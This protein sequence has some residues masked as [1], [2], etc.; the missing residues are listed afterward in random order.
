[1]GGSYQNL[2]IALIIF[3][4]LILVSFWNYTHYRI[5]LVLSICSLII[6][7][8]IMIIGPGNYIRIDF[9][10]TSIILDIKT[11]CRNFLSVFFEYNK[12]SLYMII[13]GI[14][15]SFMFAA[16]DIKNFQKEKYL[17]SFSNKKIYLVISFLFMALITV[18]PFALVPRSAVPRAGIFYILFIFMFIFIISFYL[19]SW[20]NWRYLS[21][22]KPAKTILPFISI[23]LLI[24]INFSIIILAS[25]TIYQG[26]TIRKQ[27]NER[28]EYLSNLSSEEKNKDIVINRIRG[29]KPKLMNFYE[30]STDKNNW[31]NNGAAKIYDL[32]S[33]KTKEKIIISFPSIDTIKTYYFINSFFYNFLGRKPQSEEMKYWLEEINNNKKTFYDL[34]IEMIYAKEFKDR[35]INDSEYLKILFT[36]IL[37]REPGDSEYLSELKNG[38]TYEQLLWVFVESEEFKKIYESENMDL[39]E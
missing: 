29:I 8:I 39:F 28:H 7:S 5:L 34:G 38:M 27:M 10:Q 31:I 20:V 15:G 16:Y 3:G 30:I 2:S 36:T 4:I 25:V 21:K 13:S 19:F 37:L 11:L 26:I 22:Y 17:L 33:L 6:G 35:A 18:A 12:T 32:K 9:Y 24:I 14:I 23:I 1:M